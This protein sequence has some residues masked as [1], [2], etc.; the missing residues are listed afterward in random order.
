DPGLIWKSYQDATS[1]LYA[2]MLKSG[3]FP[4]PVVDDTTKKKSISFSDHQ[5]ESSG[6]SSRGVF[7]KFLR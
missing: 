4:F 3:G 2:S 7:D 1:K 6:D 5:S